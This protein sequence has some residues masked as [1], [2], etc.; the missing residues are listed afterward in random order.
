LRKWCKGPPR[1]GKVCIHSALDGDAGPGAERRNWITRLLPRGVRYEGRVHEQPVSSLPR[2]RIELHVA[3]D[4]YLAD[5][6]DRKRHR[7]TPLLL[8]DL[9]DSPGN[10]YILYQ[11]GKDAEFHADLPLACARY[12]AALQ[13]TEAGANWRYAL[14]VRHLHC[15]TTAGR[16]DDALALAEEEMPNWSDAPDFFFALGNL[17]LA[18]ADADPDRALTEWLPLAATAWERCLAI[19]ERPDLEGSM[20]G[21]GSHLARHNLEAVRTR[22]ALQTA[23]EE[24]ALSADDGRP[25]HP[26]GGIEHSRL[27][28]VCHPPLL[29]S[30]QPRG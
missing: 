21:C 3:H 1:L 26:C 5:Q 13:G 2:A 17:A 7:N 4:G 27:K 25:R 28:L 20:Q 23:R 8:R 30:W 29:V 18:R 12:E 15:L 9:E 6:L 14:V 24:L 10:P 11:L 22:M 16:L 19:G